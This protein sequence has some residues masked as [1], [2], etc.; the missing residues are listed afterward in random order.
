MPDFIFYDSTA[1]TLSAIQLDDNNTASTVALGTPGTGRQFLGAVDLKDATVINNV[2][3]LSSTSN[4]QET[5]TVPSTK[6][7]YCQEI[8]ATY[9]LKGLDI[10]QTQKKRITGCLSFDNG[11]NWV[12]LGSL[13]LY[14]KDPNDAANLL[15]LFCSSDTLILRPGMKM[16]F[17]LVDEQLLSILSSSDKIRIFTSGY[18]QR[19]VNPQR[20]V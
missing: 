12:E 3:S 19:P 16:G 13:W 20:T 2:T 6:A 10:A 14:R 5:Y 1:G 9:E 7:F 17:K 18:V 15:P 4:Y 8:Y 11:V